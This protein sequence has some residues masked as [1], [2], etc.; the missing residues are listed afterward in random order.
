MTDFPQSWPRTW[1]DEIREAAAGALKSGSPAAAK[2]ALGLFDGQTEENKGPAFTLGICSTFVVETQTDVIRLALAA[3]SVNPAIVAADL[4]NIEQALLEPASEF[5]ALNPDAVLV[6]WRLDELS[7]RLAFEAAALGGAERKA[8]AD[9]VIGRIQSLCRGYAANGTAPL[10]ISTVP[11]PA[12]CGSR[13][14]DLH[15]GH[16][17]A[18]AV[19]R[20]NLTVLEAAAQNPLV[21]VFDFAGWAGRTGSGA[22]SAKMDF[23]ARRPIAADSVASFARH[24]G[25]TM[26]PLLGPPA[27]ALAVDLDN[28]L[29][30]GVLDE[31]GIS[32]LKADHSFPGNVYRRIQTAVLALKAQGVVLVL[33]TQNDEDEVR[34]AFAALSDMPLRL[35]DFAL[36]K[37]GYGPKYLNLIAAAGELGLAVDSFVFLDDQAFERQ[38]MIHQLPQV[39]TLA[40]SEDPIAILDAVGQCAPF[41]AYRF[42]DEDR[43]RPNDYANLHRRADPDQAQGSVEDFLHGLDL[44]AVVAPL[45][46]AA[47]GRAVQMLAR[48]NQF[49][50]TTRRHG[51]AVLRRMMANE[52]TILL[53]V[54]LSD[55]F[56]DLGI[57][58]L[59]LAAPSDDPAHEGNSVLAIDSFL[60]SCRALGRGVED[61]LWSELVRRAGA[62]GHRV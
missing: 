52:G 39:R 36:V 47:I 56:G 2:L 30:G 46:E 50:L 48:T 57:V 60:V 22:F 55:R 61:I 19:H 41:D 42:T 35:G 10:F 31:D 20:I 14:A 18:S 7:P 6:L 53:S 54:S 45:S 34:Q 12:V 23:F 1:N 13:L 24:I 16:G 59:V 17:V 4:D 32:G 25:S 49:N 33:L 29:W 58:G 15:A 9:Q 5:R 11:G 3:H 28:T 38:Q 37:A 44:K 27:K 51:E 26:A 62:A 8:A 43:R 21:H 40:V